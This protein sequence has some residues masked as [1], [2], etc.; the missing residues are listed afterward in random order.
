[1]HVTKLL[2]RICRQ[3]IEA[4]SARIKEYWD[5]NQNILGQDVEP[6]GFQWLTT[7]KCKLIL[8]LYSEM[9]RFLTKGDPA[10]VFA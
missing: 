6:Q 3:H 2:I 8:G 9:T 4:K 1:M 7:S 5:K 10:G